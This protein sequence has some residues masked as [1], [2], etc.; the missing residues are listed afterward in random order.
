MKS[1]YKKIVTVISSALSLSSLLI[2]P[3]H[4]AQI[5]FN[6]E[7]PIVSDVGDFVRGSVTFETSTTPTDIRDP[8]YQGERQL[9]RNAIVD[10]T[11]S[12]GIFTR[13]LQRGDIQLFNNLVRCISSTSTGCQQF[14]EE[15]DRLFFLADTPELDVQLIISGLDQDL[16][17][18]GELPIAPPPEEETFRIDFFVDTLNDQVSIAS[19]DIRLVPAPITSVPEPTSILALVCLS[20]S[21][22]LLKRK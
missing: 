21:I 8:F 4:A 1:F 14:L 15:P 11:F 3:A 10:F 17:V 13:T 19:N 22:V 7:G 6:F 2:L 20:G 5:T 12:T 18:T 9:Y 16:L